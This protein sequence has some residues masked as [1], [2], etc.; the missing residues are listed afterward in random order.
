MTQAYRFTLAHNADL[1]LKSFLQVAAGP[2]H[3]DIEE[4]TLRRLDAGFVAARESAKGKPIYGVSTGLGPMLEAFLDEELSRDL[5]YNLL[6]S[7]AAGLG[8]PLSAELSRGAM[9]ARLQSLLWNRSAVRGELASHLAALLNAD[10]AP[11]MPRKGGVGASGDL[12]QLAHLGLLVIGEGPCWFRGVKTRTREALEATGL[13]PLLLQFRDGLALVNGLSA[14]VAMAAFVCADARVLF[15]LALVL[16]C[17]IVEV[18]DAN[19]QAYAEQLHAAKRHRSQHEVAGRMRAHLADARFG[20]APRAGLRLQARY[21][22][23]C[24]PQILGPMFEAVSLAERTTQ[25]ELNSASDNPI[26]DPATGEA[27]HGGNFHG[28]A[29]AFSMDALKIAIVKCSLLMERRLDLLLNDA[30]NRTLPP[31]VNLGRVG[32]DLGLQGAQ[33]TA[34][35]TAA[36]NQT[37]GFPMS[38]HSISCNKGN[39]DVVSMSSNAAWLAMETIDNA[40]DIAAILAVALSQS[41]EATGTYGRLS[42]S[43]REIISR[44]RNMAPVFH[45]DVCLAEKLSGLGA[46]LRKGLASTP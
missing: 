7:H 19:P 3:V 31:F 41:V 39:Q 34:T 37:L 22:V 27:L 30:S 17:L 10:I 2:A 23:R 45:G 43:S 20:D 4:A 42:S 28:E 26:F 6:R 25:D 44:V 13:S 32:V 5:Q 9:L 15:D 1:D 40:F 18:L 33:F 29:L 21:S 14:S 35:S 8:A 46:A 24:A 36:E 16:S 12:V 11:Y 38:L